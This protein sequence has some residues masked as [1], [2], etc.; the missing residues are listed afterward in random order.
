MTDQHVSKKKNTHTK[1]AKTG[2]MKSSVPK[3]DTNSY[4]QGPSVLSATVRLCSLLQK[5]FITSG[6]LSSQ[7]EIPQL[8]I[9]ALHT[10]FV[11][12]LGRR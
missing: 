5:K 10:L 1:V 2:H 9:T 6:T 4:G 3:A 11:I 7:E 12:F 8:K